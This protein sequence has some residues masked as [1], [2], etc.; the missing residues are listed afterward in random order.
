M[1]EI[2]RIRKAYEK[3]KIEKK[4]KL[5][6]YF[7]KANLFTVHQREKILLNALKKFNFL[8][9][10][11]KKILDL[12]CG[13]G[14]VLRDFIKYGANPENCFGIDLL[15]DRIDEG[16]KLSPNVEFRCGNAE[17]L[18]Y[19]DKTFD[20]VLSFTVFSSIL[21]NRMK[22]NIAKEM[23]RVLNS[24]GLIIWY[25]Y[26][27]SKPTNPDVK[28]L[29]KREIKRL[30]PRCEIRLKQI[31]LAPPIARAIAPHSWLLCY[32]LEKMPILK[33]HYLAVIKKP[34]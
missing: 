21:D 25:D 10:S 22:K 5:Y 28:G 27:V 29:S 8:D 23:L 19:E 31:T 24:N 9:L 2:E 30:F 20:I 7:N 14:G 18:P 4:T 26:W 3:R 17:N 16:K 11:D 6:S 32:L 13:T 33:T 1:N 12:G 34:K 15:E